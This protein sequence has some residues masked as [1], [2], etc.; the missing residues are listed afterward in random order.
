AG[1]D[2]TIPAQFTGVVSDDNSECAVGQPEAGR[3]RISLIDLNLNPIPD[4]A[5]VCQLTFNVGAAVP[6]GNYNFSLCTAGTGACVNPANATV[7]FGA[8]FNVLN[9]TG[10]TIVAGAPAFNSTTNLAGGTQGGPNITQNITFGASTGGVLGGT[11]D[12]VCTPD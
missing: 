8:G 9:A 2:I 4:I 12:L 6:A 5:N 10:P 1:A 3:I 7:N 11:T